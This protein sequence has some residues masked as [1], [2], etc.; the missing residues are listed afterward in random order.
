[1]PTTPN[2]IQ[3][4]RF[5]VTTS[6]SALISGDG[7]RREVRIP[8]R[9][10]L[11]PNVAWIRD[12]RGRDVPAVVAMT[13][14]VI[15]VE[16]K[17]DTRVAQWSLACYPN[18][19]RAH[20]RMSKLDLQDLANDL[21]TD[22][23]RIGVMPGAF[24]TAIFSVP[25]GGGDNF[26]GSSFE[27]AR[28]ARLAEASRQRHS[29]NPLDIFRELTGRSR[30]IPDEWLE[31]PQTKDMVSSAI[32]QRAAQI[33]GK[34]WDS[35]VNDRELNNILRMLK[36]PVENPR[37]TEYRPGSSH[38]RIVANLNPASRRTMFRSVIPD[39]YEDVLAE[40]IASSD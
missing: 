26:F 4:T 39:D 24:Y 22:L 27:F 35:W 31:H 10:E 11:K 1:M 33:L 23:T 13:G 16:D 32:R 40:K 9:G 17:G 18:E 38:A 2:S 19:P 3:P 28:I 21:H 36:V 15:A 12:A 20:T 6:M 5:L 8:K 37:Q 34:V 25:R 7:A 30:P 14:R 29:W